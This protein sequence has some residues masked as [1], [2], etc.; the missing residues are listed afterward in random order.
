MTLGVLW[1]S[2]L[3]FFLNKGPKHP[4]KKLYSKCLRQTQTRWVIWRSSTAVVGAGRRAPYPG[5]LYNSISSKTRP[6]SCRVEHLGP[7]P[8]VNMVDDSDISFCSAR[9]WGKG[10]G[11][12]G[13]WGGGSFFGEV[14]GGAYSR[15]GG[16]CRGCESVCG[17]GWRL[18]TPYW[19]PKCLSKSTEAKCSNP[20]SGAEPKIKT[21]TTFFLKLKPY[22]RKFAL[23]TSRKRES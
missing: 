1:A 21:K 13:R 5:C 6:S 18:E 8:E 17:E 11:V 14:E 7:W 15:R 4:L 3:L 16:G 9:G 2:F 19:G 20:F 10:G 23:E 12:R 22:L